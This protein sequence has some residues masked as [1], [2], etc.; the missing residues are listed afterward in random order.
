MANEPVFEHLPIE[1]LVREHQAD[2]YAILSACD[3]AG[4]ATRFVEFMLDLVARSLRE[5]VATIRPVGSTATN[6]LE[7]AL[8]Q[9]GDRE[10]SRKDYLALFPTIS[11]ATASRDLRTAVE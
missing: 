8:E 1:S 7:R 4:G 2:Y 6:R 11:P 10:Y 3:H 5:L 9:F